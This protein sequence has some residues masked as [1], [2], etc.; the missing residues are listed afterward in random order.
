M[1]AIIT[2]HDLYFNDLP[3]FDVH[4]AACWA[5]EDTIRQFV[6]SEDSA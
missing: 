4:M 3:D 2:V 1:N 6:P 5:I